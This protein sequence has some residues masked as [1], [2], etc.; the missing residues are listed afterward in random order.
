M[1]Q[2]PYGYPPPS[3]PPAQVIVVQDRPKA[4]ITNVGVFGDVAYCECCSMKTEN[5]KRSRVG[6]VTF[7]WCC[8]LLLL[9]G[10]ILALVPFCCEDCKDTEIICQKCLNVKTKIDATCC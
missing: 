9:T 1:Y 5:V 8:F 2:Q 3:P 7:M 10:G 4:T 6:G